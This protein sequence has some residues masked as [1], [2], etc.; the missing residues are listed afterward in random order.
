MKKTGLICL[1]IILI[2]LNQTID[3]EPDLRSKI[4]QMIMVGFRGSDVPDTLA[5]DLGHR[6]L[7]GVLC[8]AYNLESPSQIAELTSSL[9]SYATTPVLV[10]VDE[11]GGYV[12]RLDENNGYEVTHSAYMLGSVLN[13]EDSTRSE[14]GKM[15]GWLADGGF[16]VNLAPVVDVNVNPNSPAIG[17][18]ERSFSADP[19]VVYQHAAWYIDEFHE[20]NIMTALKHYPGH[21]SAIDDSHDGFTDISHTWTDNELLPYRNLISGGYSDFVMAGHLYNSLIDD[22]YPASLS[23]DALSILLR[24]SLQFGGAVISDAMYMG[25]IIENYEFDEAIETAINAG[26]DILLYTTNMRDDRSLPGLIIDIVADKVEQG[27]ISEDRI[28]ASYERIMKL[29]RAFL[30][31][32]PV[33]NP[34]EEII[35][36]AFSLAAYPN[37]FNSGTTIMFVLNQGGKVSLE[38][39]NI[40]GQRIKMLVNDYFTI[41]QHR[42]YLDG[43]DLPSGIYLVRMQIGQHICT[44]KISLIK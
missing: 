6:N 39:F 28:D 7:G 20:R 12:A 13:S 40:N 30:N 21:G 5:Y 29:K 17:F 1:L 3:A 42:I 43:T 25:A 22:M 10:A 18:H 16:N 27:V 9:Q 37:P 8:L 44:N 4:G 26:V 15:A 38:L 33:V 31:C 2:M 32:A 24:D 19:A 35:P 41:G 14:A 11:E 23:Y 36:G 34:D